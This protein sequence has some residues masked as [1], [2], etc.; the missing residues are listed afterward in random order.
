MLGL[1]KHLD[2][3]ELLWIFTGGKKVIR[4]LVQVYL[5]CVCLTMWLFGLEFGQLVLVP[6]STSCRPLDCCKPIP[7]LLPL[8]L[9]QTLP[10]KNVGCHG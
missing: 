7:S 2:H 5:T 1:K 8:G 6:T 4:G 9:P 10:A 3:T